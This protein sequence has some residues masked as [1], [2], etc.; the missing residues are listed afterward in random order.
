[1]TFIDGA[2]SHAVRR[3]LKACEWRANPQYG[4]TYERVAVSRDVIDA[5]QSL[6]RFSAADPAL[7]PRRR[8][9]SIQQYRTE[10]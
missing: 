2:F 6:C 9:R 7:C 5:A 10:K 8:T 1:M 4:I 3:L